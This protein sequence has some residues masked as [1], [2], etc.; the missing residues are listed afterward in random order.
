VPTRN[1]REFKS[2]MLLTVSLIYIC[3][4]LS[5]GLVGAYTISAQN[6]ETEIALRRSQARA[7]AA[8]KAQMAILNMGKAQ[9]QLIA[10]SSPQEKR[11]AAVMAIRSLSDLDENVQH[12]QESL[13]SNSQVAELAALVAELAPAKM[14]VIRAVRDNNWASARAKARGMEADMS[15]VERLAGE[16]ALEGQNDLTSAVTD[17][18]NRGNAAI[19]TLA[20]TVLA[21]F[22]VSLL[23]GLLVQWLQSEKEGRPLTAQRANSSPI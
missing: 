2:G 9:A 16:V 8:T 7:A 1:F 20:I 22:T 11:S 5:V 17:Q 10:A 23:S 19:K 21:G 3:C 18:R 14:E 13:S 6:K 15:R 12:L 4:L